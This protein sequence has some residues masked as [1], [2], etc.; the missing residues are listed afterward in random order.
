MKS[1]ND[2]MLD[3]LKR[4]GEVTCDDFKGDVQVK[5]LDG[6]II[7]VY[8]GL[9][10]EHEEGRIIFVFSEHQFPMVFFKEDLEGCGYKELC[11]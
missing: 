6:S 5:H 4:D 8:N 9:I 11:H 3:A 2:L 10:E 1:K 7:H